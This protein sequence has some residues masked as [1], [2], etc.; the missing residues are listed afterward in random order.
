MPRPIFARALSLPILI[1][2]TPLHAI[3][4]A[5]EIPLDR[6]QSAIG[7]E[8]GSPSAKDRFLALPARS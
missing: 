1:N 4:R 6:T 3:N 5:T 2:S 8:T 7:H